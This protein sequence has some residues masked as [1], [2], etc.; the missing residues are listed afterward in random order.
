[1]DD[2]DALN[3]QVCD[4]DPTPEILRLHHKTVRCVTED[5]EALRFNTAIARLMEMSNALISLEHKPRVVVE[6][7]VLLLAP[8][9]PHVA[10]ELWR[11]LGHE[12]SLAY[13]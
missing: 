3:A 5:I 13:A 2:E 10:E 6:T 12:A 4:T 7:F 8:F 9:A 11:L 1:V